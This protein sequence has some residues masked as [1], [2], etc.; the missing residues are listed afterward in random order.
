MISLTESER[1]Y[2]VRVDTHT[3]KSTRLLGSKVYNLEALLK[4]N[5]IRP[6]AEELG[7]LIVAGE[8][9]TKHIGVVMKYRIEEEV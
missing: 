4:Y 8:L 7:R 1:T 2:R 3:H 5:M 6:T 9:T